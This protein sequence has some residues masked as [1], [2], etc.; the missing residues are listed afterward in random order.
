[1]A[2]ASTAVAV[3]HKQDIIARLAKGDRL[4]DIAPALQVSPNAISK[5]LKGDQDYRDA[6]EAGFHCRLDAAEQAIQDSDDQVDVARA[7]A[8]FQSVAWRAEREFPETWSSKS[9][10]DVTGRLQLDVVLISM[11]LGADDTAQQSQ[12]TIEH[13]PE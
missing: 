13:E 4:S 12:R 10:I 5:V 9:T 6:I 8:R 11:D 7:R 2:N 1:M 3:V